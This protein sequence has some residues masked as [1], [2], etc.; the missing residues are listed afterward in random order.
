MA[1]HAPPDDLPDFPVEPGR[2]YALRWYPLAKITV[3]SVHL[4]TEQCEVQGF[5]WH[6]LSISD[7]R[8]KFKPVDFPDR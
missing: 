3:R 4:I 6:W 2:R 7:I 1:Y 8:A 5:Q